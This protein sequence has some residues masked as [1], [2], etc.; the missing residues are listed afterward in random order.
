VVSKV[1]TQHSVCIPSVY[2]LRER[3]CMHPKTL[4]VISGVAVDIADGTLFAADDFDSTRKR[5]NEAE[6]GS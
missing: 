1:T 3:S 6:A 4:L 2:A 5:C